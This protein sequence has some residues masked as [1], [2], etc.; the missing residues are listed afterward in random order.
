MRTLAT[1]TP[2]HI[3][4]LQIARLQQMPRGRSS[5]SPDR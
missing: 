1:D 2:A 4:A 3:E 5:R